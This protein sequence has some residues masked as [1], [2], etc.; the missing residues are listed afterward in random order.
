MSST[1]P[2]VTRPSLPE[3]A[4]DEVSILFSVAN[5]LGAGESSC[6]AE[7][8]FEAT[9]ACKFGAPC[10]EATGEA[11]TEPPSCIRATKS[12]TLTLSPS[13]TFNS[14]ITP[15]AGALTSSVTL[16]VSSSRINSS[17][18]TASPTFL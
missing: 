17:T 11:F 1:S 15:L 4:I 14:E 18:L 9:E 16:S 3:P 13:L 5:F 8:L 7:I 2:L 12:P 6:C 10:E